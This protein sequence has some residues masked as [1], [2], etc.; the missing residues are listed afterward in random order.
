M[1]YTN[2]FTCVYARRSNDDAKDGESIENQ[3][4]LL[5]QYCATQGYI[6]IQVFSDD[7][8]TG[9]NFNRPDFQKMMALIRH[10]RV[11]RV[12]VKDLSRFGRN[13]FEVGHYL[14][15]ELPRY[16]VEFIA[17]GEGPDR[18]DPDSI[19]IQFKNMMNEFYAK[20]ISD[21]Q[22]LSLQARSNNGQHIASSPVF[23]YKIDP[24]DKRHWIIDEDA[25]ITVRMIF[26]LFNSGVAVPEIARMLGI[27][28]R[29]S[30]SAHMGRIKVGSKTANNPYYWCGSSVSAVLK[31]QEYCGDTVNFKTYHKSFKDK[32]IQYKDEADYVIIKDTQDAIISREEFEKAR[33]RRNDIQR[34]KPEKAEHI[35]DS[36]VFCGDCGGRLYVS[37][38]NNKKKGDVYY[39]ICNAYKKQKECT[40]H[41]VQENELVEIVAQ[42]LM[43]LFLECKIDK[44]ELRKKLTKAVC[45]AHEEQAK[46]VNKRISEIDTAL[47]EI[48]NKL[49]ILF[50]RMLDEGMEMKAFNSLTEKLSN[51]A[52]ALRQEQGTLYLEIDKFTDRKKGIKSFLSKLAVYADFTRDEID[53]F[54]V[55]QLID[56][57]EV[58]ETK[59]INE[60]G[61]EV[62]MIDVK[63][64]FK[65]I[66]YISIEEIKTYE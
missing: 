13:T 53:K 32:A 35:L 42:A 36:L 39:Y 24:A 1:E 23:G 15:V 2:L 60:Y 49:S 65:E 4:S 63:V 21:K 8:F 16:D 9:T 51:D 10:R 25:A 20:D 28:K 52:D 12:I 59:D 30:P 14:S 37:K 38:N 6:N 56:K 55:E 3:V 7:G 58:F 17:L 66:G 26:K 48:S 11:K 64:H 33:E 34:A 29:L 47:T 41:Y 18:I 62:T 57:V 40:S 31:R 46:M 50:D 44:K 43:Y 61:K 19:M 54:V 22:K 5:K 27:R 45:S